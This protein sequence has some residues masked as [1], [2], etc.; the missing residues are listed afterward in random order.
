MELGTQGNGCFDQEQYLDWSFAGPCRIVDGNST[1]HN[2]ESWN[3]NANIFFIDQPVGVGFSYA[4]YGEF[5]V[6]MIKICRRVP[7]D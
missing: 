1:E 5:V 7:Y 6:C 4:E 3:S 2:P